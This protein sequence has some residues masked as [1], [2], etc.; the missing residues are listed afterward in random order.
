M[1]TVA[2][3]AHFFFHLGVGCLTFGLT[4]LGVLSM[5]A[6]SLAAEVYGL[7]VAADHTA[8]VCVAG[9]RDVGLA[10]SALALYLYEP[11]SL[12]AF[13][14]TLLTIPCGDAALTLALGGT[15][16]GAA[17]HLGGVFAIGVLTA[18]AWLDP[19]LD[20]VSAERY[21]KRE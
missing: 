12:R 16:M 21:A 11:R 18:C 4:A 6:P 19:A 8:W 13:V 1:V 17:T 15:A 20:A 5:A 2:T 14:P 7:P 9:L 10:A 3:V